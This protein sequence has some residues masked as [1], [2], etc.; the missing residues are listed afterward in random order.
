MIRR[1]TILRRAFY[2]LGKGSCAG[3]RS[4]PREGPLSGLRSRNQKASEKKNQAPK[5]LDTFR[6]C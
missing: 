1:L 2:Y 5:D 3:F 4:Q 6:P